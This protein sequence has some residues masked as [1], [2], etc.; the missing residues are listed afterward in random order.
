G[1]TLLYSTYRG[2][3]LE[4][5]GTGIAVDSAINAYVTGYTA[6]VDFPTSHPLQP[7]NHGGN[8]AFVA[9]IKFNAPP[10]IVT[11]ASANPNPVTGTTTNLSVLG[12]DDGGEANLIYT[13]AT[14]GTSPAPVTFSANATNAAK[15]VVA[16]FT[17]AGNYSF[18][19]TIKDQR[20]L[21]VTSSVSVT[22]NQTLSSLTV[23]PTVAIVVTGGTQQFTLTALDQFR[24]PMT[25]PPPIEWT[26]FGGGTIS[27]TG[28]FTAGNTPGGPPFPVSVTAGGAL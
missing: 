14:T 13:W 22:V 11:P 4:E 17:K 7:T 25:P 12:A 10:T 1:S 28:L 8:D 2:G 5:Y 20:G 27:S 6:S 23:A 24:R 19:V 26:V 21:T 3:S 15:N 9:R 16:R 18:R